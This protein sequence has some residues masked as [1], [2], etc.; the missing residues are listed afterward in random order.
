MDT[1]MIDN[2]AIT[3]G[4]RNAKG[5]EII[6]VNHTATQVHITTI[7]SGAPSTETKSKLGQTEIMMGTSR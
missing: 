2:R 1:T 5:L 6:L 3:P 7:S 4:M